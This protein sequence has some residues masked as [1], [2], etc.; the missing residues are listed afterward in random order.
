M[1]VCVLFFDVL[2]SKTFQ[3]DIQNQQCRGPMKQ[4]AGQKAVICVYVCDID[5]W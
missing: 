1:G 3:A 5:S 2:I 4:D